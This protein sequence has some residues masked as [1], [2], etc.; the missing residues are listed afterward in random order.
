LLLWLYQRSGIRLFYYSSLLV[1]FLTIISLL[2]D[3][4]NSTANESDVIVLIYHNIQG[5][6]T[7]IV[8]A[9]CFAAYAVLLKK[10]EEALPILIPKKS[11]QQT[12]W[13]IAIII[14][15]MTAVYGVNLIF[16]HSP[17]YHVPNVYH[18]LITQS[19]VAIILFMLYR[20]KDTQ[21]SWP[22]VGA[23][24]A[25]LIYHLFSMPLITGLRDGVLA[26][27]YSSIHLALHWV[28]VATAL[29]LVYQCIQIVR[30]KAASYI[31]ASRLSWIFSIILLIF[32][33]HEAKHLFVA[34][35]YNENNLD[36]LEEQYAKAVL[37]II[38][39]LCSFGLM[40][41]GMRYKIKTLRIISLS[42]FCLALLKLFFFDIVKVS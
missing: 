18:R 26:G 13:M 20:K 33:S 2:M 22:I 9:S 14:T 15:Y 17:N 30:K 41:L 10:Q 35:A 37:T 19:A 39:A 8:A 32:F 12:G 25:Y 3:W 6:V 31:S 27:T 28:S 38:W 34:L 16:R 29:Y 4:M 7:N 40:W 42:I 36:Y 1:V 21:Y 23:V 11:L 24:C 5:L